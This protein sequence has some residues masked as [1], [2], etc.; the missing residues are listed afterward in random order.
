MELCQSKSILVK[1]ILI[2]CEQK[3]LI[4]WGSVRTQ[5]RFLWLPTLA[6]GADF[7]FTYQIFLLQ[8]KK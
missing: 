5:Y 2:F 8:E 7:C 6:V 1:I 3:N 4:F